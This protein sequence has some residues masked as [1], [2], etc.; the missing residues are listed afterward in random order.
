MS[1][2]HL[3][4]HLLVRECGCNNCRPA[5]PSKPSVCGQGAWLKCTRT[6][7]HPMNVCAYSRAS[8]TCS[9]TDCTKEHHL[10]RTQSLAPPKR[11]GRAQTKIHIDTAAQ[12]WLPHR[13]RYKTWAN[14]RVQLPCESTVAISNDRLTIARQDWCWWLF[15]WQSTNHVW[16]SVSVF[17]WKTTWELCSQPSGYGGE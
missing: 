1:E 10:Y 3:F 8:Y 4:C 5:S 17:A 7:K 9:R 13:H 11:Y 16:Q 12:Q 15:S 6:Q 2:D 14:A